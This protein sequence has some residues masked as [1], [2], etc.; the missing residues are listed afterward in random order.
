MQENQKVND[1]TQV[2]WYTLGSGMMAGST[3]LLTMLTGHWCDLTQVGML[4]FALTVSQI[5]YA[6]ALFGA[7]DYQITDVEHRFR[8]ADY[9]WL[10]CGSTVLSALVCAGVLV[11]LRMERETRIC[12]VILTGF[13][14]LNSLAE[15][16]QSMFFQNQRVD[17][18]GKA[19]FSHYLL[20]TVV[21]AIA[22]FC[23]GSVLFSC[24]AMTLAN[25]AVIAYWIIFRAGGFRDSACGRPS[26]QAFLLGR[27][28]LPLCL[29]ILI[30][31]VIINYPK[32][33]INQYLSESRQ[34]VYGILFMP[35]YAVNLLGQCIFKPF[36]H[37]YARH[38]EEGPGAFLKFL[39]G[40]MGFFAMLSCA[41]AAFMFFAGPP[42]LRIL[43]GQD[44][45]S[46]RHLLAGFVLAGGLMA[47]NQ[48]LYYIMIILEKQKAVA[49][50]YIT[51][52]ALT[53]A[54]GVILTRSAG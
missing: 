13:M 41:G 37:R 16:Y 52:L 33:L 28:T 21:F 4:T 40:Q 9:F 42:V 44:I 6:L 29:G 43:F 1:R 23:S 25:G 7:N 48:Q 27:Q 22:L 26:R 45:S 5:L 47:V 35:S 19:M 11:S 39:T 50:N 30:S 36:L 14:L 12:T 18:A 8:F 46:Y 32:F 17:L 53:I 20:A 31:L 51:A 54:F 3:V 38:W 49:V 10:K 15:L 24:F 2:I 34:G